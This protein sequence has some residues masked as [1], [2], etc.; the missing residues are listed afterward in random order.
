VQRLILTL[1]G[2]YEARLGSGPVLT[3]PTR[4][5]EALLA[6]LALPPGQA[7]L[8]DKLAALLWGEVPDLQ[9]RASLRQALSTLRQALPGAEPARL[10]FD[11]Q[12][13]ALNAT[14]V[15]VDVTAFETCLSEG[16]PEG[17]DTAARL[18]RGDLLAGLRVGEAP[19]E[20]WLLAER[21]RLRE[22]AI[23]G[24]AR[25]LA[26]QR[27]AGS[28]EAALRTALRLAALDPLQEAVHRTVM[29]LY[30]Q[31]GRRAAALSQYQRCVAMLQRELG[32]EP[33][34]ATRQLHQEILQ[35]RRVHPVTAE[36]SSSVTQPR[37]SALEPVRATAVS[38]VPD[39]AAL[40]DWL[41]APTDAP[42]I[43]RE[44]ELGRLRDAREV[45]RAGRGRLVTVLGEAGVGKSRLVAELVR[46][47]A[48]RGCP[49]LFGRAWEL[50]RILPFAPWVAVLRDGGIGRESQV[51]ESLSPVWR[52]EL[53]RL[54][55]EVAD[56]EDPPPPQRGDHRL[57][58]EAIGE[59]LARLTDC[60]PLVVVLEDLQ[61]ADEMSLRLLAFLG[62]RLSPWRLLLVST[63]R[64]EELGDAPTL[65]RVLEDLQ[66]EPHVESFTLDALSEALTLTLVQALS[67]G[68]AGAPTAMAGLG[69]KVWTLSRGNPFV[70]VETV[71][72]LQTAPPNVTPEDP[73]P[74]ATPVRGLVRRSLERLGEAG[75]QVVDLAA[76][77]GREFEFA[78]LQRATGLT[79][80]ETAAAIDEAVR[81]RV[82]RTTGERFDF[83]HD[84]IREVAAS[85][86]SPARRRVLHG[87]IAEALEAVYAADLDAHALALGLHYQAGEVWD[88]AVTHLRRA[89]AQAMERAAYG[90]AVACFDR[91]LAALARIAD[92]RTRLEQGVDVRLELRRALLALGKI[93]RDA[94]N[95]EEAESLAAALSDGRRSARVTLY[96]ANHLYLMGDYRASAQLAGRVLDAADAESLDLAVEG[97]LQTALAYHDLADYGAAIELLEKTV[98]MLD[99]DRRHM[100]LGQPYMPFVRAAS[101]LATSLASLGEFD[102][103]MA[104]AGEALRVA[105]AT[106]DPPM[107]AEALDALGESHLMRWES[108]EAI[109]AYERARNICQ[110]WHLRTRLPSLYS[111]LA[112][113]YERV[114]RTEESIALYIESKAEDEALGRTGRRAA[115]ARGLGRA[116]LL[117]GRFDEATRWAEEALAHARAVGQRKIE[118]STLRLVAEIATRREPP[119]LNAAE[120]AYR[121][122]LQ[123]ATELGT[124]PIEALC[125]L[126]LGGVLG[127]LS[128]AAEARPE[129]ARAIELFRAMGMTALL[130]RA[131]AELTPL[132]GALDLVRTRSA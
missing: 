94:K 129:I 6:Y 39:V 110:T 61:W 71:R 51:V 19:F 38:A 121:R 107:L 9:A 73:L 79:G 118:A 36:P 13:V 5:V 63:A 125:R 16:T 46:E 124:R 1:F 95:L 20:E 111:A 55:P 66:R 82:L 93:E 84:W 22:L 44:T 18:Y 15:E 105:E 87:R 76:V 81:R 21:E 132:D 48:G 34:A 83:G 42:L 31:L 97:S 43:G 115:R 2:G 70:A 117:T 4:K 52:A 123:L 56:A 17:L 64:T 62:R 127:R 86:V 28:T 35:Q 33:E 77:L 130:D 98:N 54:L 14:A 50:E 12:A 60:Q 103:A 99:G 7:H 85:D 116:A 80:A 120:G 25:L 27:E 104:Y 89:G 40:P 72:A 96:R 32:V 74:L 69:A 10:R 119:D 29:R 88:R 131:Q 126:E 49:V 67:T 8:R 128:R 65:H 100:R 45:V 30:A 68:P 23:E 92:T 78:L 59:L 108:K 47:S 90:E 24:L 112:M 3:F 114:G 75:R 41:L 109:E 113:A 102:R 53:A 58:F 37:R 91:A 57:L 11:G 26:H 106:S 101:W 122:C